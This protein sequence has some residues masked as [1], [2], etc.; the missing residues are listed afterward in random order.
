M[1]KFLPV[2]F[3]LF[4]LPSLAQ[5]A[6]LLAGTYTAGKS[7]GIYVYDFNLADGSSVIVDSAETV[8]PSYLAVSPAQSFV[9]AVSETNGKNPGKVRAYAFN[10]KTGKLSFLNEQASEGDDPCYVSIDRTG[11][12]LA[13]GNYSSGSAALLPIHKNGSLGAAVAVRQHKG[14]GPNK[15]RQQAAHV[16][17][18]VFSPDNKYLWTPDLGIDRVM[19]Y[20]FNHVSGALGPKPVPVQLAAGSGP[21]H[22]EIHPNKKWVYLLK[23]LDG[24]ISG[25]DYAGGKLVQFQNISALPADFKG[26]FTSADIHISADGKFLYSSNRDASNTIAIFSIGK[27]GKLANVGYQSTLGK[28]PRNFSIDPSG[29]HLLVANQNSDEIVVF[30]RNTTTGLLE[31][32]GQRI[33]IGNP[34][35]IKWIKK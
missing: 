4:A 30:N 17:A 21:R 20:S 13:V 28:T 15:N 33:A 3:L 25:F 10:K 7:K 32:S 24:T 16:H 5:H 29:K 18:A 34:V 31:D 11:K 14:T 9:Y 8:N 27:D 35:C 22:L 1:K 23:E 26:S 6:Y 2:V 12:W 19:T